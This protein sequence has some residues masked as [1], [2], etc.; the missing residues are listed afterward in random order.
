MS[1]HGVAEAKGN[2]E[3]TLGLIET[4]VTLVQPLRRRAHRAMC[5]IDRRL[6]RILPPC[7]VERARKI[8]QEERE[9]FWSGMF[10]FLDGALPAFNALVK[11]TDERMSKNS[12][13]EGACNE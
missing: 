5:S 2:P 6:A 11:K 8:Q 10:D 12:L 7:L 9:A 4:L 1:T 13:R 3:A